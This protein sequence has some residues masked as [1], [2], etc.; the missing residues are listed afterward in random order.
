L[1]A[2]E[3]ANKVATWLFGFSANWGKSAQHANTHFSATTHAHF[4][5]IGAQ[6]ASLL[7]CHL[8]TRENEEIF[9]PLLRQRSID[10]VALRMNILNGQE[11]CLWGIIPIPFLGQSGFRGLT[12]LLPGQGEEALE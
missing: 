5:R 11:R 7:V 10:R 12:S 8:S 9:W 1:V 6:A 3:L 4:T 2:P